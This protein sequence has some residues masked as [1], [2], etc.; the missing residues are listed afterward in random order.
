[1]GLD[2]ERVAE[3]AEGRRVVAGALRG[4]AQA[5]ALGVEHGG[6]DLLGIARHGDSGWTL[7]D[8]EVPGWTDLVVACVARTHDLEGGKSH[9]IHARDR[10]FAAHTFRQALG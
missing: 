3:V 7:I 9:G 2:Q 8:G 10:R 1:V 6:D 5:L 4:D